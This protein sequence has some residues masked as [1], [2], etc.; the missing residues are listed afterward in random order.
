MSTFSTTVLGTP[1]IGPNRELKFATEKYWR[2]EIDAAELQEVRSGL[3]AESWKRLQEAGIDSIPTNVFSLYDQMLDTTVLVGALPKQY[4]A[5]SNNPLD[6]YFAA[7]RGTAEIPPLEMTKWFDTNYHYLV[8]ELTADVEFSL[9]PTELLADLE[10]AQQAEVNARPVIVGPFTYLKL[11]KMA[12]GEETKNPLDL[13]DRLV[14]VYEGVLELLAHEGVEWV[15]L[16]EPSAVTTLTAEEQKV[17]Q[18]VYTKLAGVKNR[19]Q[20]LV[21]TY[22]GDTGANLAALTSTDIDGISL[23]LVAGE[24]PDIDTPGLSDKLLVAGVVDGRNVWA[25]AIDGAVELLSRCDERASKVAVS[26]SCS[27]LHVP[28]SLEPENLPTIAERNEDGSDGLCKEWLA[29]GTEKLA[30]IALLSKVHNGAIDPNGPE[31]LAARDVINHRRESSVTNDQAVRTRI[32]ELTEDDYQRVPYEERVTAQEDLDL[33]LFPTTTIGSFPQTS[34]IRVA[35]RK[36]RKGE[37]TADEYKKAMQ[38]EVAHVIKNQEEL[39]IDV[40]VH[41]EPERNDMVQYFAEQLVGYWA[42]EHGWV[43]SYGTRCVRPPVLFGDVSRPEPMSVEWTTYAASLTDKPVKGMLT[44]PLTM[45][46]W[47]F[48]RDDQ[49]L[50]DTAKQVALAIRDECVD[51]EAAGIRVIQVDEPALRELLPLRDEDKADYARWAVATFRLTTSGVKP[52]TQIHTHMCY[53]EFGEMVGVI[54]ELDADVTS[55]ESARSQMEIVEDLEEH[56]YHQGIGPG[57]YDIHSPR[58]PSVEEMSKALRLALGAVPAER[59]WVNPDCGLK[60]RRSDECYPSL[61]NMVEAARE[62]RESVQ[63]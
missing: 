59:L 45:L 52:E 31:V 44:G 27:L 57:I 54:G 43:Q 9:N 13:I 16:D 37:I 19:P 41:G 24:L 30:E 25:T 20:I 58:V 4:L 63:N 55:V 51:L 39:G 48:V 38:G 1:R 3:R 50:E 46:S 14:P 29:F 11:S 21:A 28:Y 34:E 5:A 61:K 17:L 62:L 53:S 18:E 40:L 33:P 12:E 60:T 15:Q 22:F 7:A 47:S 23:D 36:F 8:P 35:R 32:A 42:S 2:G 26:S 6:Q 49:S 10:A 56:G